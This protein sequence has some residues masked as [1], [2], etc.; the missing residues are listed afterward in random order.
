MAIR[1]TT[2]IRSTRVAR[3]RW[4]SAAAAT[5][6]PPRGRCRPSCRR[7]SRRRSRAPRNAGA[8]RGRCWPRSSTRSAL[9]PVR[10]VAPGALGIA[11]FGRRAQRLA[12]GS[13]IRSTPTVRSTPRPTSC[14]TCCAPSPRCRSRWPPTTPAPTASGHAAASPPLPRT[15]LYVADILGLLRPRRRPLRRPRGRARAPARALSGSRQATAAAGRRS[16]RCLKYSPRVER[17]LPTGEG[18]GHEIPLREARSRRLPI[19]RCCRTVKSARS[20]RRA[21]TSSGC[22]CHRWTG[23]ASSRRSS[24]GMRGGFA[25]ARSTGWSRPAAAT[26][27]AP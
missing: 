14:A 16:T 27:R 18:R 6:A 8:S 25:R 9:Q 5:T 12:T 17:E 3:P 15:Q 20:S 26:C 23:R 4:A 1:N 11:Q 13:P 10:A 7:A 24:T 19:T 2:A 22:R 21:G